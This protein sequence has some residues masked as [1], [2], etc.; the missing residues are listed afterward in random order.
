MEHCDAF[1]S[2]LFQKIPTSPKAYIQLF[3]G[4][5]HEP[6]YQVLNIKT[7]YHTLNKF[8]RITTL[9]PKAYFTKF[10]QELDSS[11]IC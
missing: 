6:F 1:P 3:L 8:K 10:I 7:F 5:N 9:S 11:L 4:Q 2:S